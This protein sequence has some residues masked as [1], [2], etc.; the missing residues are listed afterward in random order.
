MLGA[1]AT[2]W[3]G[4]VPAAAITGGAD[5]DNKYPF[6]AHVA[7]GD[8]ERAC[9][10]TLVHPQLVLTAAACFAD[11]QGAVRAGEPASRSTVTVGRSDLAGGTGGTVTMVTDLIPHPDRD[12]VLARLETPATA[13]PI[14]IATDAPEVGESLTVAGFG[15]TRTDWVPGRLKQGRSTVDAVSGPALDLAAG[16]SGAGVCKGDA[17]G[18]A[19][20]ERDGDVELVAV[21]HGSNQAGCLGEAQG[22]PRSAETRVDDVRAWIVG[23]FPGFATGFEDGQPAP[24]FVSTVDA[25]GAGGGGIRNVGGICCSLTGPEA[26]LRAE[27]PTHGGSNMLMYSGK[28]NNETSSFAYTKVFKPGNLQVRGSTALSYWIYP[29]SNAS[30]GG[31]SGNNSTCVAVD[32]VYT[33]GS[34]LRDSAVLDQ[35][36]HR[37]HP[38]GQCDNLPLDTWTEVVVR[39]GDVADGK[40]IA[41]ISVGYDQP[42]KLGGYRGYIDDIAITDVV[43]PATFATGLETGQPAPTWTSTVSTGTARGGLR[44]VSG[45]CCSLTGPEAAVRAEPTTHGGEKTLMYSGKD[46]NSTSSFAYTKVFQLSNAFVTPTSRLSYWIHPQSNAGNH[47]VSGGNSSCV[48]VDLIFKAHAD[49]TERSLRDLGVVDQ[50]G[51]SVHPSGQCE[52]LPLDR[53]SYVSVPL[54]AVANGREITQIDIGY[55][56]KPGTGGY[57]GYVDDIRITP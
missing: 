20:R 52:Q 37:P 33:D 31:V 56:Q 54:G 44:N 47:N 15:R 32:L 4:A 5:A 46:D 42:G 36:G 10:G 43:A 19:F 49:G 45:I 9:S 14:A 21:H 18:P 12:L 8:T 22:A 57:R 7:V 48:A 6:V 25:G 23:R 24:H 40:Q 13:A 26:A 28:D 2:V 17:G 16:D 51:R 11:G 34:T 1:A 3:Y 38:A 41:T 39:I 53:W 35:R 30:N 29:Q 27:R 55:D 50:H